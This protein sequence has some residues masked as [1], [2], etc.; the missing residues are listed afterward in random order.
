MKQK[1]RWPALGTSASQNG[2]TDK[3]VE[4]DAE[5][6]AVD[7]APPPAAA[8]GSVPASP[9]CLAAPRPLNDPLS[10][11]SSLAPPCCSGLEPLRLHSLLTDSIRTD[12]R[13][14][15]HGLRWA[16]TTRTTPTRCALALKGTR[17]RSNSKSGSKD[18]ASRRNSS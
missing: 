9:A 6:C 12:F 14:D 5:T 10:S 8:A 4:A 3:D 16:A 1:L 17:F 7:S 2:N 11:S 18:V 15:R 13:L